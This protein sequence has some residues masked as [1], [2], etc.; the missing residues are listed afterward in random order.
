MIKITNGRPN[1]Y[2]VLKNPPTKIPLNKPKIKQT[3][4]NAKGFAF[5]SALFRYTMDCEKTVIR[6]TTAAAISIIAQPSIRQTNRYFPF[7]TSRF[8]IG[9]SA[10]NTI[11]FAYKKCAA[12]DRISGQEKHQSKQSKQI[13][14]Y[15]G[16]QSH[17]L[18]QNI[19]HEWHLLPTEASFL[20][21]FHQLLKTP[22]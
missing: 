12:Q 3:I 14:K 6:R 21:D 19:T 7:T 9:R 4:P 10:E 17:F 8:A 13:G 20:R 5:I 2:A 18:P 22:E 16:T 1:L 15:R 11:S